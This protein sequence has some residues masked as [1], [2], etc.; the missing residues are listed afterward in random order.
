ME[1]NTREEIHLL[2]YFPDVET[3]LDFSDRLYE[4]LPAF[5]YDPAIWGRQLVMDENDR[6][7][8]QVPKL[9]TLSLIHIFAGTQ[10]NR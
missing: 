7:L 4:A 6:V 3:A 8:D 2:C 10:R 9:L 1:A 5:P